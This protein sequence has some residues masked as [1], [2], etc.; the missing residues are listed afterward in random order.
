MTIIYA[1]CFYVLPLTTYITSEIFRDPMTYLPYAIFKNLETKCQFYVNNKL[2]F[3]IVILGNY[4]SHHVC[5]KVVINYK[6]CYSQKVTTISSVTYM[7]VNINKL[8]VLSVCFD[9]FSSLFG[10]KVSL[11]RTCGVKKDNR[12]I[13]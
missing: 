1:N 8:V 9:C 4:A 7:H 3:C 12:A 10:T 13:I 11:F 5:R 6:L 2:L